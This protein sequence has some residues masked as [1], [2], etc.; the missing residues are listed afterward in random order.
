MIEDKI[1]DFITTKSRILDVIGYGSGVVRQNGYTNEKKQID[2]MVTVDSNV[3]YHKENHAKFDEEYSKIGYKLLPLI[4]HFGTDINYISNI[5]YKKNDFKMGVIERDDLI[6]DLI[7]WK[8]FFMAGRCQKPINLIR[9]S[10]DVRKAIKINRL[11]ALKVALI[12]NYDKQITYNELFE[13][14]CSLSYIGDIRMFFKCE[15]PNKIKNIV[16]ASM[17]EYRKMYI[18]EDLY[19]IRN[20]NIKVNIDKIIN[21]LHNM[22]QTILK[23]CDGI[24]KND[25]EF[26]RKSFYDNIY[27]MN[28]ATSTAQP[29]KSV[30][31]N[32]CSKSSKYLIEKVK[33]GRM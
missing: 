10:N 26:L 20:G 29:I 18:N 16:D 33:K 22:P 2:L 4:M 15:N 1:N 30:V 14:I 5:K 23:N 19:V 27:K 24:T 25:I 3:E 6:D 9:V 21:E 28:L 32:G 7:N 13:T 11:N 17:Y 31:I 8:N 12:L